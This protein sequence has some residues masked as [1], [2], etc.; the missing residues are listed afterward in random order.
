MTQSPSSNVV[1]PDKPVIYVRLFT[2]DDREHVT[3]LFSEVMATRFS[4]P[5]DE[6]HTL[7]REYTLKRLGSD[8]ADIRGTYVTPGG[9]FWVAVAA[10][11]DGSK[12][13]SKGER[14]AGVIGLER[15]SGTEGEVRSVFVS[16]EHHRLGI[17]RALLTNL[18][19][20]ARSHG[21]KHL[22]LTTM[23]WNAQARGF[24]ASLGFDYNPHSPPLTMFDGRLE[25]AEF[26][27]HL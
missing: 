10:H 1:V 18:V 20:W 22:F 14:I 23:A 8:L 24:Y 19:D 2:D 5:S 17:G 4:D 27:K 11:S 21:F 3:K 12:D 7:W 15:K 13:G 25:L 16:V 26:V 9:N 6:F